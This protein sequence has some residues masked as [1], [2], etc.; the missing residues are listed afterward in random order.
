M[1]ARKKT[2]DLYRLM[3]VPYAAA[4]PLQSEFSRE[5][6]DESALSTKEKSRRNARKESTFREQVSPSINLPICP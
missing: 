1:G 2:T 3:K 4:L 5:F 6:D